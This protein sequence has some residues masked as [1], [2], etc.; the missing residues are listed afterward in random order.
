M[1]DTCIIK[2]VFI[3][4]CS[5]LCTISDQNECLT[6]DICGD[7]TCTNTEGSFK[8]TCNRGFEPGPQEI[9]EGAV[10]IFNW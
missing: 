10:I 5:F 1:T 2:T 9:C 3:D 6:R 7:G 8:C 4:I